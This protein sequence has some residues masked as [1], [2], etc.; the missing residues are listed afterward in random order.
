MSIQE[1]I[2]QCHKWARSDIDSIPSKIKAKEK[3]IEELKEALK[4]I[5]GI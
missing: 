2:D 4:S 3:E 5:G 1:Q